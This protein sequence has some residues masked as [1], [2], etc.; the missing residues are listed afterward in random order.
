MTSSHSFFWKFVLVFYTPKYL[1]HYDK[2]NQVEIFF[3]EN[4]HDNHVLKSLSALLT[5]QRLS[6]NATNF[7][8]SISTVE[9]HSRKKGSCDGKTTYNQ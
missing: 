4:L 1:N 6:T 9:G 8:D 5:Y 2:K 7:H 3:V